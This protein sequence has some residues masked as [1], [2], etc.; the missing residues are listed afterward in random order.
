MSSRQLGIGVIVLLGLLSFVIPAGKATAGLTAPTTQ[1]SRQELYELGYSVFLAN[2]NP[3]DA[4]RV[5]VMALAGDPRDPVWLRRA[6]QAARWS[7]RPEEALR[8]WTRLAAA[9]DPQGYDQALTL[10]RELNDLDSQKKL[11]EQQLDGGNQEVLKAYLGVCEAIGAPDEALRVL[12]H[13]RPQ[14]ERQFILAQQLRLYTLTGEPHRALKA[15]ARLAAIRPLQ[16]DEALQG[17]SLWYGI[18]RPE[19]AWELLRRVAPGIPAPEIR[20][21]QTYSDLGW[22]LGHRHQ[23]AAAAQQLIAAGRGRRVDYQRVIDDTREEEPQRAFRLASAAWHRFGERQFLHDLFTTGMVL[24]R[25]PE[26]RSLLDRLRPERQT[27]LKEDTDF[28]PLAAQV[29][30]HTGSPAQSA[31]ASWRGVRQDPANGDL[32]AGHLWLLLD[33]GMT[34]QAIRIAKVWGVRAWR[35]PSLTDAVGAVYAAIGDTTRAL[36][37]YR[38][39]YVDHRNDPAWLTSYADLLGQAG[40]PEA[41]ELARFMAVMA[42]RKAATSTV[43]ASEA[44]KRCLLAARLRLRLQPGDGVDRQFR[45]IA[46]G[47]L[48]RE[49]RDLV[50]AWLLSTEQQDM[51]RLWFLKAYRKGRRKPAWARLNL[52]L[53]ANDLPAI[54]ALLAGALPGLPYRD[55]VEGAQRT[56]QYPLAES[57]AFAKFQANRRDELLDRQVRDLY[58]RHPSWLRYRVAASDRSGVGLLAQ[59]ITLSLPVNQRISL[60]ADLGSTMVATLKTGL[61]GSYPAATRLVR[62]ALHSRYDQG[63]ITV[64]GGLHEGLYRSISGRLG[65]TRRLR[66]DLTADL[67]VGSGLTADESVPLMLGGMK[68]EASLG[69]IWQPDGRD[70]LNLRGAFFTFRDQARHYLG[71]GASL[72]GELDHRFTVTWPDVTVRLFGG[73]HQHHANGMPVDRAR[74]L[75]PFGAVT[76]ASFFIP[77]G[78]WQIGSGISLGQRWKETYSRDWKPFAAADATWNSVSGVGYRYELGSAGPLFGMDTLLFSLSQESG[79]FGSGSL[80]TQLVLRYRYLFN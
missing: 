52:A 45:R 38:V 30:R 72:D 79:A 57:L 29:Y 62:V 68:D 1:P 31:A 28:W 51:A 26:L 63:E 36:R 43:T 76:D 60:S 77:A 71:G 46:N 10:A 7:N 73:L 70:S 59:G 13:P 54:E 8:C 80:T 78:F 3:A 9:G 53:Q 17:A 24:G 33:L 58:Q 37:F 67:F 34:D 75:I 25:W 12:T 74:G 6:A 14:W 22:G 23:S 41:A 61:L 5:A 55:A 44:R 47:P 42:L 65:F 64:A 19:Q 18:G 2:N 4:W 11:L 15:L 35:E 48:D 66:S 21:W 20:F 27:M 32:V 16:G 56:G 69:L 49:T 50:T 39:A 40:R